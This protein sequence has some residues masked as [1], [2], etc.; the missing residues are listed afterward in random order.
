MFESDR[1]MKQTKSVTT[2]FAEDAGIDTT[3]TGEDERTQV[4]FDKS[5]EKQ[6]DRGRI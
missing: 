6:Q 3:K 2:C 4:S 5:G 1:S